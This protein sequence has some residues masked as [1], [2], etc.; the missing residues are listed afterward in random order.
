MKNRA[1]YMSNIIQVDKET[2]VV[3]LAQTWLLAGYVYSWL[4]LRDKSIVDVIERKE[5]EKQV[6]LYAS[7]CS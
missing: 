6:L 4:M 2:I 3:S 7:K 1:H 5:A